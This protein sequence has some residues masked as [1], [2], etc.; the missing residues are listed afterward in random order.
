MWNKELC[1]GMLGGTNLTDEEMLGL[2]K[3]YA[4][5]GTFQVN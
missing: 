3:R 4:A 1:I 5:Q 2:I